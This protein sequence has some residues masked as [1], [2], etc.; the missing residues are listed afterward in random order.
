M[1][2]VKLIAPMEQLRGSVKKDCVS[3]GVTPALI[4]EATGSGMKM[5]TLYWHT[6]QGPLSAD[7][8]ES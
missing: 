4:R 7:G 1:T 3:R 6:L 2:A 8:R 5:Q